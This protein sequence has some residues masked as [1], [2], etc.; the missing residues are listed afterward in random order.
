MLGF[1]SILLLTAIVALLLVYFALICVPG[2]RALFHRYRVHRYFTVTH[3]KQHG[4][5][6]GLIAGGSMVALVPSPG[7][8]VTFDFRD[9]PAY[10]A[11]RSPSQLSSSSS[12]FGDAFAAFGTAP[13][14]DS[15][16]G[17][18]RVASW[19]IEFGYRLA[20]LLQELRT[21]DA[22]VIC[23]Q[24]CD[25]F[26]DLPSGIAV[27]CV[28]YLARALKMCAVWAGGHA[29]GSAMGPVHGVWGCAILSRHEL[30]D[31]EY[32]KLTH[33]EGYPRSAVAAVARTPLGDV[34]VYS[35]HLEVCCGLTTRME[36]LDQISRHWSFYYAAKVRPVV[37]AGDFNSIGHGLIRLSPFHCTDEYR[38]AHIGKSE[39]EMMQSEFAARAPLLR[40]FS[41]PFDKARDITYS[42][43]FMSAKLDWILYKNA[44]CVSCELQAV[45][46]MGQ[47]DHGWVVASIVPAQ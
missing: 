27:D 13:G 21:L 22:D 15:R 6:N 1:F 24:E 30:V 33:I 11:P 26:R 19:N 42:L 3:S 45:D 10:R 28:A 41:D 7:Q 23:L 29:Y 20:A 25:S 31:A 40:D 9:A 32:V 34:C 43:W 37:I 35:L 2:A 39:A 14:P 16:A 47:S 17:V 12:A 36:Q 5:E 8:L 18:L 46:K 38:F 4:I 44:Q